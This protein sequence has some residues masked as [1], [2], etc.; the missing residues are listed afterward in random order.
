MS[1]AMNLTPSEC[2]EAALGVYD[3]RTE[4]DVELA[5]SKCGLRDSFQL[6]NDTRFTGKS[7]LFRTE[8]GFGVVAKASGTMR[9]GEVV[10]VT[11]G[12]ETLADWISN[13]MIS[14]SMSASNHYVHRGFNT[15]FQSIKGTLEAK[16]RE[17][18]P[19]A[20]H[21]I[22]HSLG[23]A[24]A[25]LIADW[26]QNDGNFGSAH[27]YTFGCPRVGQLPF[28]SNLT[29]NIGAENFNR[30]YHKTDVVP[31]IPLWPFEH[32]PKPGEACYLNSPGNFPGGAYHKMPTYL[33]DLQGKHDWSTLRQ[34]HPQV[35]MD[36]QIKEW[37]QS[38]SPL[39]LSGHS[40]S[41]IVSSISYVLRKSALAT[42]QVGIGEGM[43]MLDFLASYLM[44]AVQATKEGAELVGS[45]MGRILSAVGH[46]VTGALNITYSFI[47]WVLDILS[48]AMMKTA[49]FAIRSVFA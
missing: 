25:T 46:I 35:N 40:I 9:Q 4:H 14:T 2:A 30:A 21:C 31:M 26:V 18:Q 37:L 22:G 38:D 34:R 23:G 28:V 7:G 32:G 15:I 13:A 27:V 43:N 42:L 29:N 17:M 33:E 16:L 3:I 49:A 41:M 19:T 1:N 11:R 10:I 45:L 39:S 24:L 36:E 12:T 44:K 5:F 20:V 6:V 8:S 48:S 47:R